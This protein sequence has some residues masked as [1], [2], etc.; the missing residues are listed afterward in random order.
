MDDLRIVEVCHALMPYRPYID[1]NT[2]VL[3][4][5]FFAQASCSNIGMLPGQTCSVVLP[6]CVSSSAAEGTANYTSQVICQPIGLPLHHRQEQLLTT[7]LYLSHAHC[8][9]RAQIA[10]SGVRRL[11]GASLCLSTAA[12]EQRGVLACQFDH[13]SA[14]LHSLHCHSTCTTGQFCT[15]PSLLCCS[16]LTCT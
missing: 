12:Q 15:Q 4:K 9:G 1:S 7:L 8:T 14:D 3:S 16:V 11:L 10:H 6:L 2:Y 5:Q 13:V